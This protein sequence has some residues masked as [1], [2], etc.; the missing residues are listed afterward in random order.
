MLKTIVLKKGEISAIEIFD[1]YETF[2]YRII[3]KFHLH[4]HLFLSMKMKYI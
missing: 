3:E 1:G 2:R 4:S